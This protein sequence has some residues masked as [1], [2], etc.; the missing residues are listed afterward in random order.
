MI[1]EKEFRGEIYVESIEAKNS[2]C[3]KFN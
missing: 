3:I 1:I 2:F